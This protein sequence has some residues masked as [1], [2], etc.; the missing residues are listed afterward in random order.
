MGSGC[1]FGWGD[2][3]IKKG[4]FVSEGVGKT[5]S[6][7]LWACSVGKTTALRVGKKPQERWQSWDWVGANTTAKQTAFN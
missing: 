7:F 3:L 4:F 2:K 6:L 1:F 5:K